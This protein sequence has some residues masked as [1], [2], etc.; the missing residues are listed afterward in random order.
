MC[1]FTTEQLLDL[2]YCTLVPGNWDVFLC[3]QSVAAAAAAAAAALCVAML[4]LLLLLLLSA[5]AAAWCCLV[6][7]LVIVYRM[8]EFGRWLIESDSSFFFLF[9]QHD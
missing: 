8:A 9:I 5:A 6:L 7:L 1:A 4:L 2:M 3:I